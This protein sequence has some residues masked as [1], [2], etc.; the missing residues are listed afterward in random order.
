MRSAPVILDKMHD[1]EVMDK[2][3]R[4]FFSNFTI[5]PSPLDFKQGS[6]VTYSLKEPWAG[7]LRD[8]KLVHGAPTGL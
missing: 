1:M 8:E 5:T 4:I 7:F 3:L 2:L 6:T